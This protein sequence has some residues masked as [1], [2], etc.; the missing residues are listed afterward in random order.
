[1]KITIFAQLFLLLLLQFGSVSPVV[2]QQGQINWTMDVANAKQTML[3]HNKPGMFYFFSST[4]NQAYDM[5]NITF[6]DPLII[7]ELDDFVCVAVNVKDSSQIAQSFGAYRIPTAIFTDSASREIDRTIGFKSSTVFNAHI[8]RVKRAIDSHAQSG[9]EGAIDKFQTNAI[10][11]L[12]PRT[13]TQP[14]TVVYPDPQRKL[15]QLYLVG[16]FNN[17]QSREMPMYYRNGHWG[18]T[19]H[20]EIGQIYQYLLFTEK[21]DY[22]RDESNPY[23]TISNI[24][25]FNNVMVV[26][27][28]RT[29]PV[30]DESGVT[31][32]YYNPDAKKVEVAGDFTNWQPIELFQNPNDQNFW[33]RKLQLPKGNFQYKFIVN[34]EAWRNDPL[35]YTPWHDGNA[36]N[37]TFMVQ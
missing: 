29:S 16:D 14:F 26:G 2:A 8:S 10:N 13:D 19:V 17:W 27:S 23:G 32:L 25:T 4:S 18:L 12:V 35:N 36:Y 3:Y 11:L 28:V 1:M 24:E 9:D 37:S 7:S 15:K 30:V 21:G 20:L 33:G 5:Q 34:G 31:F 22:L 6:Q